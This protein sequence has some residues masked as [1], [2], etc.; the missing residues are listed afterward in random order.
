VLES[1]RRQGVL[2]GRALLFLQPKRY[3]KEPAQPGIY[4]MEGA[5]P[6]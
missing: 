2:N 6:K 3:P 4:A 1:D 5:E